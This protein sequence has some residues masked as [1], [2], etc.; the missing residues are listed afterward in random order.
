MA[1]PCVSPAQVIIVFPFARLICCPSMEYLSIGDSTT[2]FPLPGIK[3][4]PSRHG[5]SAASGMTWLTCSFA[6]GAETDATNETAAR[7]FAWSTV[8][9]L[10]VAPGASGPTSPGLTITFDMIWRGL[11]VPEGAGWMENGGA[12]KMPGF[13][14]SP[15]CSQHEDCYC[16]TDIDS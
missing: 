6:S 9:F 13:T 15:H 10:F 5:A 12:Q 16:Q 2:K 3:T 8:A 7:R 14:D 1:R 4:G 11:L